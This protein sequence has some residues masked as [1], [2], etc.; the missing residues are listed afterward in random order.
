MK[1]FDL[2]R[3]LVGNQVITKDGNFI[4][5]LKLFNTDK[6]YKL[7]GI[8]HGS[9]E[10]WTIN[11]HYKDYPGHNNDLFM[12]EKSKKKLY[13]AVNKEPDH[14]GDHKTSVFA[15]STKELLNDY[16]EDDKY[17][18]IEIEIEI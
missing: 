10:S 16:S 3:A 2:E 7:G 14:H 6:K 4:Y 5:E 13:I 8:L 18:I 17:K 9:I 11:G 15:Y 1:P 12:T